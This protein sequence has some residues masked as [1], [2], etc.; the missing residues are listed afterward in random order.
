VLVGGGVLR[1]GP[2]DYG[3]VRSWTP[4][5]VTGSARL[6]GLADRV[7]WLQTRLDAGP[8]ALE[9]R[10]AD[11]AAAL[12]PALGRADRTALHRGVDDLLGLG[13]GLTPAGDDVLAGVLAVHAQLPMPPA[14]TTWARAGRLL[15]SYVVERSAGR[16]TSLSATLLRLAVRGHGSDPVVAVLA[17]L[18]GLRPLPEAIE[19]LLAVGHTSG[20]DTARGL[21]IGARAL[22][23]AANATT[24]STLRQEGA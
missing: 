6:D 3:A 12:G 1:V 23:T 20:H 24:M 7:A 22:C 19:Q 2:V 11:A 14:S 13:A 8:A 4:R 21:E 5:R 9:A 15:G 18:G 16:T 17:A 10:V